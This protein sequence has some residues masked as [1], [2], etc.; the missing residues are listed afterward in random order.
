MFCVYILLCADSKFYIGFT[1][2][3]RKRIQQHKNGEVFATRPRRPVRLIFY[4]CYLDK[5]DAL[6][7]VKYLKT[8]KGKTTLKS[9][10]KE[11]LHKQEKS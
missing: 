9:M 3:L 1:S 6:R 5:Y 8:S 10:L 11:F 4:E 7:R 2:D